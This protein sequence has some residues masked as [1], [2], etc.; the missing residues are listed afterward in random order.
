MSTVLTDKTVA[1]PIIAIM[2]SGSALARGTDEKAERTIIARA[3]I[4]TRFF[5]ASS[6]NHLEK[7][8]ETEQ[9]SLARGLLLEAEQNA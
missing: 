5:I 8:P 6:L 4:K 9:I 3:M 7:K 2:V 1:T